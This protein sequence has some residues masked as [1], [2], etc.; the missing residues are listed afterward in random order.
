[1]KIIV[2]P[3]DGIGP[4]IVEAAMTVLRKVDIKFGLNLEFEYEDAGFSSLSKYGTTLRD[5][6]LEK[7]AHFDGIILGPISHA[8]Y[9]P[10]QKGGINISA[11]FRVDLQLYANIRPARTRPSLPS[12]MSEGK[13]MDLVIVRE[14]TEG[15]YADRNMF[16]GWGEFMPT[17][18]IALAMRKITRHNSERIARRAF[19]LAMTR[20]KKLTAVHKANCFHMTDGLFLE[21]VR[22]VAQE[23]PDVEVNDLLVDATTAHLVRNPES[24]DVIVATNFYGDIISD[25]ASELA[26]GLGLAGSI[27]M[28]DTLCCAQTQHGS[29]PDI[30]GQDKANPVSMIL[31]V[32]MLLRWLGEFNGNLLLIEAG[33]LI[34]KTVD[35]ILVNPETRTVDLGG[36]LGCKAF[37]DLVAQSI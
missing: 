21:C 13:E 25:L 5:E 35:T 4:E 32:S 30:A 19:E 2:I 1:M 8:D 14:A 23:F 10:P 37:S 20:R 6:I 28:G 17:P 31:S 12:R 9:P 15:F 7:A 11:K 22:N 24:F 33:E 26:G 29:A 36:S 3:C 34:N 18:D 16:Q 27:M